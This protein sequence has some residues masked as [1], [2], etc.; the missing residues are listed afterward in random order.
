ML[1]FLSG[2][3][4]TLSPMETDTISKVPKILGTAKVLGRDLITKYDLRESEGIARILVEHVTKKTYKWLLMNPDAVFSDEEFFTWK[5]LVA[6]LFDGEPIQYVIGR[7]WF[8]GLELVVNAAVLIPRPETEEMVQWILGSYHSQAVM[9][10]VDVG[11]GSGAIALALSHALPRAKVTGIDVSTPALE[12][13]RENANR[14]GLKSLFH[15]CDVLAAS[16]TQFQGLDVIVSN[17]P[18]IPAQEYAQLEDH[19]RLHE[20]ELALAVP[21][22][23]PLLYYNKVCALGVTWLKPGGRLFFE[24]HADFGVPMVELMQQAGYVSVELRQD[25]GGRDR[26]VMGQRPG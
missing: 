11:T 9:E 24:I 14:L 22:H 7:A 26:M 20:P 17:P 16:E 19:V 23:D 21:D 6:R 4:F 12:V 25:L 10:I 18:Y 3:H 1:V 2:F 15:N 8:W 5:V 13:A